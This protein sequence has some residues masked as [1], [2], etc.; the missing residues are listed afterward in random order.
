MIKYTDKQLSTILWAH[1][2]GLLRKMGQ[3]WEGRDFQEKLLAY[4][5]YNESAKTFCKLKGGCINQFAYNEPD[6]SD[7]YSK[8]AP[9]KNLLNQ[10]GNDIR[11]DWFDMN[12]QRKWTADEFLQQL[13]AQGFA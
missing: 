6:P 12:Y 1:S 4:G 5:Y 3:N 10:Y 2:N 13:V 9:S 7:A 11:A 8:H